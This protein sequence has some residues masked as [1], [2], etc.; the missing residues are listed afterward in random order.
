MLD[1][2]RPLFV[3]IYLLVAGI[4]KIAGRSENIVFTDT[5]I[6]AIM[7]QRFTPQTWTNWLLTVLNWRT[8]MSSLSVPRQGANCYQAD[9]R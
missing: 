5:T 3:L 6:L 9:T 7:G 1:L 4:T 2:K 8:T